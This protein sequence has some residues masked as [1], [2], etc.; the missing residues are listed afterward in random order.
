MKKNRV[1]V[2]VQA[3]RTINVQNLESR[4]RTPGIQGVCFTL[5]TNDSECGFGNSYHLHIVFTLFNSLVFRMEC[6]RTLLKQ[7]LVN[8]VIHSFNSY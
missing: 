6:S 8:S 2:N 1:Q 4:I 5:G 7:E 3:Y